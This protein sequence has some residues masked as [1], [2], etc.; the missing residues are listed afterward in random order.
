MGKP[1]LPFDWHVFNKYLQTK[2]TLSDAGEL[3]KC[4]QDTIAKRVRDK[5]DLTYAEYRDKKMAGVRHTLVQKAMMYALGGNTALLIFLLKNL[6]G[7]Q[8][9][10]ISQ[11]VLEEVEIDEP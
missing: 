3:M 9:M 2:P 7:Y 4:S 5:Y 10:P 8:D 1:P 11:G 6:C